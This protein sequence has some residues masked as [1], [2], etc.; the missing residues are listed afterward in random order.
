MIVEFSWVFD[1]AH[2]DALNTARES[3]VQSVLPDLKEWLGLKT[4]LDLGCGLGYYAEFFISM[5][6]MF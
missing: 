4:A 2:Y 6:S 1:Q 3:T 5:V